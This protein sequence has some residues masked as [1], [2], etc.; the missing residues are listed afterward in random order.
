[1]RV[2]LKKCLQ[3]TAALLFGALLFYLGDVFWEGCYFRIVEKNEFYRAAQLRI[4]EWREV[5]E[6]YPIA[7]VINLRGSNNDTRWYATE[8]AFTRDKGIVHYNLALSANKQPDLQKMEKLVN[9][10]KQAP[11]PLLVHCQQ[12]ADRT[13]LAS[14]LYQYAIEG[15]TADEAKSQLSFWYGHFPWLTSRTGA[16][17]RA[18]DAYVAAHPRSST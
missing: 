7:S 6:A 13:G 9:M 8:L 10:M 3:L 15:E 11:K 4:D 18:F 2:P 14:A 17:D 1:M 12:G 16:M 5:N